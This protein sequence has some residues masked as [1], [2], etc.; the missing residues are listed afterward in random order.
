MNPKVDEYLSQINKWKKE[1][2]KLRAIIVDCGLEEEYKWRLP[3]YTDRKKNIVILQNFKEYCAIGFFKGVLLKDSKKI[4][5]KPGE[6][7]QEGRY[8]SFTNLLQIEKLEQSVKDYIFEAVEIERARLIV[9]LKK[10]SD[11]AVPE[12]LEIKFENDPDFKTAFKNLTPG[13]QRGY[14]L[15]FSQ[16]KQ[17]STRTARIEKSVNRIMAGKGFHDCICG[18]SKRMPNCDG[19][20]KN[21]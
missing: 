15:N 18:M 6:N 2:I 3:C 1:L 16:P 7:T 10:T 12:E 17:S 5:S 11:Y 13:R 20:H 14:L 4:L 19:S 8:I 21:L 9:K